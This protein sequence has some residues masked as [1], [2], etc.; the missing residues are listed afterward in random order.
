MFRKGDKIGPYTLLEKLGRG[1]FGV[2]WLAEKK[3]ALTVTQVAL[4]LPNDDDIEL[5]AISRE[6][7]LWVQASGHPNV[8]PIID[9]DIYDEQVVI[10]S[11]Y[12]PDGSLEKWLK[13]HGGKA[14]NVDDAIEMALGILAGLGHLHSKRIIHR[15]LKPANILLQGRTPRL[16]DFGLARVMK[17]NSNSRTVSGTYAYM[18]PETFEGNRSEQTDIWSVGVMLYEMLTGRLPYQHDS[19]AALVAAIIQGAPDSLPDSINKSLRAV[20]ERAIERDLNRRFKS[21]AEMQKA[22]REAAQFANT[23]EPIEQKTEILTSFTD[24]SK[25]D[26]S[27]H[28]TDVFDAG[29]V[30]EEPETVAYPADLDIREIKTNERQSEVATRHLQERAT[31]NRDYGVETKP[32]SPQTDISQKK[33][34]REIGKIGDY[35]N[36]KP[37]SKTGLYVGLGALAVVL[38]LV[39]GFTLI[40]FV[41]S[42]LVAGN[43]NILTTLSREDVEF[44]VSDFPPETLKGLAESKEKRQ[45]I[46]KQL[47]ELL[48]LSAEARAT[49][50]DKTPGMKSQLELSKAVALSQAYTAKKQTGG[51][52]EITKEE[53]DAYLKKPGV[54]ERFNTFLED[55]KKSG[56]V[57]EG[58]TTGEKLTQLKDQWAKVCVGEEKALKEGLDKERK[59]QIQIEIQQALTLARKFNEESEAK[60]KDAFKA[61][62]SD[63]EKW[64]AEHPELDTSKTKLAKARD[65]LRRARAGEDF[66]TL[67]NENTDDPGNKNE[68]GVLMGGYYD[69]GR[70][71]M[72]KNFEEASFALEPG[73]ISDLVETPFG[74]HI[75]KLE[76]KNMTKNAD[77]KLEEH[78]QV[79]HILISTMVKD[80]SNPMS[81]DLPLKEKAKQEIEKNKR[82]EFINKFVAK[83]NITLPEDFN[84]IVPVSQQSPSTSP[85]P[86][87]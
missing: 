22:L 48:A 20:V 53:T 40:W 11:E 66:V 3:S 58:D 29:F 18:P 31:N 81:K 57:P 4:K 67:A 47:K 68:K 71:V 37:S 80:E 84:V 1:G 38:V 10:V 33:S 44:L 25:A 41:G 32:A 60:N 16:V 78:V 59:V 70:G 55:A 6:A 2:V 42:K 72:D 49:G 35:E 13:R 50:I 87:R 19:D 26:K 5:D 17:T 51:G 46:L 79:R 75:I 27:S 24:L 12:A 30:T 56:Q 64:L 74:Y 62:D 8:L 39:V 21:V 9:A 86:I 54:E 65:L 34:D 85:T 73:Q 45:D 28:P 76:G 14:P 23:T 52:V 43:S 77:G 82:E 83:H 7:D 69:F 36:R 63:I 61:T 15:D